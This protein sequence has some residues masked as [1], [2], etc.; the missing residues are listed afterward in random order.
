MQWM[1]SWYPVVGL[2]VIDLVQLRAARSLATA[3]IRPGDPMPTRAEVE[4]R[5]GEVGKVGAE[6]VDHGL[7]SL[8]V[9]GGRG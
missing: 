1:Q 3:G 2:L 8:K 7:N 5:G 9:F 6:F 4:F